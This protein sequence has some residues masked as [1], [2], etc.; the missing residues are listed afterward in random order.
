MAG[1]G[2]RFINA[3]FKTIKPLIDIDGKP[4]IE[5]ICKM[6]PPE[7]EFIFICNIIFR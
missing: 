3:G 5:R 1:V 2:Q 6:F 7:S 4:M